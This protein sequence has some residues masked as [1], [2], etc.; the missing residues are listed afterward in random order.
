MVKLV[1]LVVAAVAIFAALLCVMMGEAALASLLFANPLAVAAVLVCMVVGTCV[2]AFRFWRS[3]RSVPRRKVPMIDWAALAAITAVVFITAA[4]KVGLGRQ[5]VLT[6]V[7][8][9][10]WILVAPFLGL[11]RDSDG[12]RTLAG[13]E[14]MEGLSSYV[15]AYAIGIGCAVFL[16]FAEFAESARRRWRDASWL[17]RSSI[18]IGLGLLGLVGFIVAVAFFGAPY[19]PAGLA[20]GI[21]MLVGKR[22]QREPRS[23]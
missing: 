4:I 23:S 8:F 13:I 22:L 21:L 15:Y 20:G 3:F 14:A 6:V 17:D 12:R 18:G 10:G 7:V 9:M 1:W 2:V 11:I 5:L 16:G 19:V